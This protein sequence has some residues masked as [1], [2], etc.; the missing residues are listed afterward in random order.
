MPN[1]K[2]VSLIRGGKQYAIS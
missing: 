2:H 1:I